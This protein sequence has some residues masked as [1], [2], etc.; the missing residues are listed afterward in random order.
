MQAVYGQ[1]MNQATV[2]LTIIDT[3]PGII[4][5]IPGD[6]RADS[7]TG[8]FAPTSSETSAATSGNTTIDVPNTSIATQTAIE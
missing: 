6:P 7:D 5:A 8:A 3:T 4:A 1:D 2:V